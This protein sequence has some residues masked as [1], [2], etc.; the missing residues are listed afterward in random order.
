MA[1][2]FANLVA[3]IRIDTA[4]FDRQ[5]ATI[6]SQLSGFSAASLGNVTLQNLE[7]ELSKV[8][9]KLA[10]IEEE[11]KSASSAG[12]ELE[13]SFSANKPKRQLEKLQASIKQTQQ[14]Y[15][16]LSQQILDYQF[17]ALPEGPGG[18]KLIPQELGKGIEDS[19][20]K[21]KQLGEEIQELILLSESTP[22]TEGIKNT[23]EATEKA[24]KATEDF[25]KKG[26]KATK[27]VEVGFSGIVGKALKAV[28]VMGTVELGLGGVN[29]ATKIFSGNIDDAVTA[30]E[31]LPAGIGPVVRQMKD[32]LGTV[33]EM[34]QITDSWTNATTNLL[35]AQESR[36]KL[37][38]EGLQ[39]EK[40]FAADL[41]AIQQRILLLSQ[42]DDD[43]TSRLTAQFKAEQRILQIQEKAAELR[44]QAQTIAFS[45]ATE[46][47]ERQTLI[48]SLKEQIELQEKVVQ[49]TKA[50]QETEQGT[51]AVEEEKL[52]SLIN[53]KRALEE[54]SKVRKDTIDEL[55]DMS[56]KYEDLIPK[57]K[58]LND[59]E[60]QSVEDSITGKNTK[61]IE[62]KN[63]AY[64]QLR[65]TLFA[66]VSGIEQTADISLLP[67]LE[68]Q[69]AKVNAKLK[70]DISKIKE[71]VDKLNQESSAGGFGET[72]FIPE[73]LIKKLTESAQKEIT[74]IKE[75]FEQDE[76]ARFNKL[77]E[78]KQK[79]EVEIAKRIGELK[80]KIA[81]K[82]LKAEGKNEEAQALILKD[83][84]QKD[85]IGTL[86]IGGIEEAALLFKNFKLDLDALKPE[87]EQNQRQ[88]LRSRFEDTLAKL[89]LS[90]RDNVLARE[91]EK[92]AQRDE[93]RNKSLE[94]LIEGNND[95][96]DILKKNPGIAV[97][98]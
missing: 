22:I 47:S 14:E 68:G 41:L 74:S 96:R 70:T 32:L 67:D 28:A 17:D 62:A 54:V 6:K 34:K 15:V 4:N 12:A 9:E 65:K 77:A 91:A 10:T 79:K 69:I 30:L 3:N 72:F 20:N 46:E 11:F 59:L 90:D 26:K 86:R 78:Q 2:V 61:E 25:G 92:A 80:L 39:R 51:I 83:K 16:K 97:F 98:G 56:K 44:S 76:L 29:V 37:S 13:D 64:N 85:L 60:S 31:Q 48:S 55:V 87:P 23:K 94:L 57:A 89:T 82:Q 27:E 63:K 33:T 5:L 58:E 40:T 19:A 24:A 8:K 43:E 18:S 50:F 84:L 49:A 42:S 7:A 38:I 1:D 66:L 88:D 93:K 95:I 52:S 81:E 53:E 35:Q 21:V 75:K 36:F 71:E 45:S 73:S